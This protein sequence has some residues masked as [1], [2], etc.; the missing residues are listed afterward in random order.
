MPNNPTIDPPA[1][2]VHHHWPL[3]SQ[4]ILKV[5]GRTD[6]HA[7][8]D[9]GAVLMRE[10]FAL[11]SARYE[12]PRGR[13]TGYWELIQLAPDMRLVLTRASYV[14]R[15]RLT[16]PGEGDIEFHF[17]LSG[18]MHW[19]ADAG[20]ALALAEPSL[21]VARQPPGMAVP[22]TIEPGV[23]GASVTVYC[24]PSAL[25]RMLGDY[26]A[27]LPRTTATALGEGF[28]GLF[29]M[30]VALYP[31]LARTVAELC[32]IPPGG[33]LRL[34]RAEALTQQLLCETFHVLGD[35]AAGTDRFEKLSDRDVRCLRAARDLLMKEHQPPPPIAQIARRTGLSAKKLKLGFRILFGTTVHGFANDLRMERGLDLLRDNALSVAAVA[36]SLGFAFQ[37]SFT[38]AFKRRY[39]VLPRDYR[40][41]PTII[42]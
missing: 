36:E 19:N 18:R 31:G 26:P 28:D 10:P 15:L 38:T 8:P 37:T 34:A 9:H 1:H 13:G 14:E 16:A 22:E 24:R 41:D 27:L 23:P 30:R 32:A 33:S 20:G 40:R 21:L 35:Q 4:F 17:Q 3:R 29:S 12:I 39:G 11:R 25:R 6:S 5:T 42:Q 7:P 2:W